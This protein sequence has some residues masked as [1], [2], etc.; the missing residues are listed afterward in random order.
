MDQ[1]L[2]EQLIAANVDKT[3]RTSYKTEA[4]SPHI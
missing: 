1:S 3:F 2:H 4:S